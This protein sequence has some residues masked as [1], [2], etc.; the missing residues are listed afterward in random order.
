[1]LYCMWDTVMYYI[2]L[3]GNGLIVHN[4]HDKIIAEYIRQYIIPWKCMWQR[5]WKWRA[6]VIAILDISTVLYSPWWAGVF[7]TQ[8]QT[9]SGTRLAVI[10]LADIPLNEWTNRVSLFLRLSTIMVLCVWMQFSFY[11]YFHVTN[12]NATCYWLLNFCTLRWAH[13]WRVFRTTSLSSAC[14][15]FLGPVWQ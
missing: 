5:L 10:E 15:R 14:V 3:T 1:M 13:H 11:F 2:T 4:V 7:V 12:D 9:H 8:S 6:W